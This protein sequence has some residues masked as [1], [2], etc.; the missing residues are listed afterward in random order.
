MRMGVSIPVFLLL[1]LTAA[2]LA[3]FVYF[4]QTFP[5]ELALMF[6]AAGTPV[7]WMDRVMF[8]VVF[9]S[10]SFMLPAFVAAMVGVV[11]RVLPPSAILMPNAAYWRAAGRIEGARDRWLYYGAWLGCLVQ[12]IILA[13]VAVVVRANGPVPA[14]VGSALTAV[15]VLSAAAFVV[16]GWRVVR[17]FD[18]PSA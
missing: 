16:W 7:R 4:G 18:V 2:G 11:P 15:A 12:G 8:I 5:P 3:G 1:G 13:A 17:A 14:P 10:L 9:G 6:D